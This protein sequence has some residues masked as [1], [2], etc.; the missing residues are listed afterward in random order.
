MAPSFSWFI[1]K[2]ATRQEWRENVRVA[3]PL[4]LSLS[5]EYLPCG[6]AFRKIKIL[7]NTSG[8]QFTGCFVQVD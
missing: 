2:N 5:H 7:S 8:M 4:S 6:L 1:G 3:F